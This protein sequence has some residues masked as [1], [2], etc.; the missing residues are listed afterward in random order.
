MNLV[1]DPT[2]SIGTILNLL[3]FVFTIAVF[4]QRLS[5]RLDRLEIKLNILWGR[6]ARKAGAADAEDG[7]ED[8]DF[9]GGR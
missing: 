8:R 9:F 4:W 5:R 6:F 1:F 2:I 7:P 3:T